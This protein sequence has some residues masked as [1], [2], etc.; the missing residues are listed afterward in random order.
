MIINQGVV[1]LFEPIAFQMINKASITFIIYNLHINI[2]V[3][4]RSGCGREE[5]HVL[6]LLGSIGSLFGD[7]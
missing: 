5:Q 4:L 7:T 1:H 2:Q 3:V 6:E